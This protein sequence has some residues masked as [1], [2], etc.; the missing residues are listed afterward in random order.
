MAKLPP[1][2]TPDELRAALGLNEDQAR[3]MVGV[4]NIGIEDVGYNI[5]DMVISLSQS[6]YA[7]T[8]S[9]TQCTT[10]RY[11]FWQPKNKW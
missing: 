3:L 10:S 4:V 2:K 7:K 6:A 5:S 8:K 9:C 11:A 1:E